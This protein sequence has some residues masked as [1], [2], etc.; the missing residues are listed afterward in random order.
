MMEEALLSIGLLIVLAKVAE[1]LL[2]RFRISSIVAY[3]GTGVILGPVLGIVEATAELEILLSIG[4]FLFFF[5][6][7]LDEIDVSSFMSVIRGRFFI[8]AA[9]AI[10]V[11][12]LAGI[13]VTSDFYFDFG[14]GLDF[15]D[16][17]AVAGVLALSSLGVVAKVLS[18]EGR[19][20]EPLGLQIFAI[21]II[22]ELIA[23]LVV[24]FTI[25]ERG[26]DLSVAN[27]LTLLGQM[28]GFTI[29]AWLLSTK[30][31]PRLI[32]LLQRVLRVPHLSFGL[33]LGGL[34]LMV[35]AAEKMGV[36]GSI[37]ALLFG[38]ALSNLPGRIRQDVMPGIRSTADGLFVPL[39][40]ASAG[41]H[42]SMAFT[43]L[44]PLAIAAIVIIPLAGKF[45]GAIVGAYVIRM[46]ISFPLATGLMAKG[47][48]EIALLLIM[49][50]HD[51]IGK[52]L[53]SLLI[54]IMFGYFLIMPPII[55]FAI[56]RVRP[57]GSDDVVPGVIPAPLIRFALDDMRIKDILD[58]TPNYPDTDLT[59][60]NFVDNWIVPHQEEYV[61]THRGELAGMVSLS[62]LRYLP[63]SDWASTPL[64]NVLSRRMPK[65]SPDDF[66]EDVLQR[67]K[68]NSLTVI[69]VV[70]S[71]TDEFIGTVTTRDILDIMMIEV[72]GEL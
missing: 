61:V 50:N 46:G 31:I 39:F 70:N 20:R 15:T 12:L 58:A 1:G 2:R 63:K 67:M 49:H 53:F 65:A 19:L 13:A 21:V 30:V 71:E 22:A 36:H 26:H 10:M 40:F 3:A 45:L 59:V 51:V 68:E 6:I 14:L 9:I 18:D 28:V 27:I 32:V 62:M 60:R 43:S 16:A 34:F 72:R 7:G 54:L 56:N 47:A 35:V 48:A 29:V 66:V 8:A 25:G 4:V 41:L 38:V 42:L 64:G 37:G 44:P 33:L 55:T 11:P 24:G 57:L 5:L 69:P 17:L 52:D 23:L